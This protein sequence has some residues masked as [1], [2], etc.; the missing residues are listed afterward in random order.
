MHCPQKVLCLGMDVVRTSDSVLH[1][2]ERSDCCS[3]RAS[4]VMGPARQ[5]H[6]TS[7]RMRLRSLCS[8]DR[9]NPGMDMCH[10]IGKGAT[11]FLCFRYGQRGIVFLITMM[12]SRCE[13]TLGATILKVSEFNS[14]VFFFAGRSQN[15]AA[16]ITPSN[17]VR[18]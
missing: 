10:L 12:L 4:D 6:T 1:E 8:V 5:Y 11:G 16:C 17:D 15:G 9:C 7:N 14:Y 18:E 2:L 13:L 3:H